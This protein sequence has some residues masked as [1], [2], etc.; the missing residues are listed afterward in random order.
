MTFEAVALYAVAAFG[1]T[2]VLWVFYLAVMALMRARDAGT[3]SKPAYILGLPVLWIGLLI[4]FLVNVFV[5]SILMLEMPSEGTVTSRLSRLQA[6]EADTWRG[7]FATWFCV[8]LL[9][10]FDPTGKHCK[11]D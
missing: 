9:D 7:K 4:D 8:N 11:Q 6:E 2:Y 1:G 3:L 10:T 5:M